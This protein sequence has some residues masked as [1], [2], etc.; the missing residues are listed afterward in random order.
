MTWL[1]DAEVTTADDKAAQAVE[2]A[3]ELSKAERDR[4]LV[5]LVYTTEA[6]D[7]IQCRE[8]DE[9]RIR[10]AADKMER[11]GVATRYWVAEDN[12]PVLVTVADLRGAI[13]HGQD[14][15]DRIFAEYM[16]NSL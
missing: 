6:G 10:G 11:E 2:Q 9:I 13:E 16:Q 7:V 8:A 1:N 15:T 4:Q 12:T 14:E 5:A 3:R